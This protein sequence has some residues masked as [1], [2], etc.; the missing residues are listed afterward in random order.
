MKKILILMFVML[1]CFSF[2]VISVGCGEENNDTSDIEIEYISNE[3]ESGDKNIEGYVYFG[4][5]PTSEKSSSV[6]V[7]QEGN[8]QYYRDS[9]NNRY[10]KYGSKY[11]KLEKIKWRVIS[12]NGSNVLMISDVILDGV[13][14]N[15][16][17]DGSQG[18]Y[19]AKFDNNEYKT[20]GDGNKV[21]SNNY[22]YSD[23]RTF[24]N[25]D[26][27]NAA[28]TKSEKDL[29]NTSSVN[30]NAEQSPNFGNTYNYGITNDK[31]FALSFKELQ[32]SGYG[33]NSDSS[34]KFQLTDYAKAKGFA[35]Q[36]DVYGVYWTR[37][38]G[39]SSQ[40]AYRVSKDGSM[41]ESLTYGTNGIV[42]AIE[43]NLNSYRSRF[44]V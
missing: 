27:F 41:G 3:S 37:S 17:S 21:F 25:N 8:T 35:S 14:F 43:I 40:Y 10:I 44:S 13:A 20:D 2:T 28:F 42:P 5:Y 23:L 38:Y 30:N 29:I 34:R 33:F 19:Y 11:Y 7:E 32:S 16:Y 26:F 24:L 6:E 4:T 9:N 36:N 39:S 22:V 12:I 1:M 18:K 15:K 31:V